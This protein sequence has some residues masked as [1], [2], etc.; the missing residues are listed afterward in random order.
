M[1]MLETTKGNKYY[2]LI[3]A[4]IDGN[5]VHQIK[6][7]IKTENHYKQLNKS[8]YIL[9]ADIQKTIAEYCNSPEGGTPWLSPSTIGIVLD[10]WFDL[11]DKLSNVHG[12]PEYKIF[13]DS[14]S[15]RSEQ[16]GP[17]TGYL[18]CEFEM[19]YWHNTDQGV[20]ITLEKRIIHQPS[21]YLFDITLT[22]KFSNKFIKR[23]R[24]EIDRIKNSN[25]MF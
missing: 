23:H 5:L 9:G 6:V 15:V 17:I 19:N 21:S 4:S 20:D 11:G 7:N 18:P 14:V 24:K 25:P 2:T 10:G 13:E 22:Y 12:T 3:Q 8:T 1:A 16:N